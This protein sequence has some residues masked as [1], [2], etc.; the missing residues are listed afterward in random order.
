MKKILS[1]VILV[2]V[3]LLSGC[4]APQKQLTREEWLST[5][6]RTYKT[7]TKDQVIE[8]AEKVFRLA[9]GDDFNIVHAED[10]L[11]ATRPWSVYLVLAAA[12][13]IDY[14]KVVVAPGEGFVKASVQVNTSMQTV[15]P[16]PTVGGDISV[17]TSPMSGSPVMGTAIY[18][19]FWARMDYLLGVSESW[20]TCKVADQRVKDTLTWGTN[21]ALCNIFNIK[22][23]SPSSP[24]ATLS[25]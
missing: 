8:A 18:D 12:T 11:M 9:D 3:A 20:M 4:A 2:F 17:S 22:D 24:I 21:E 23:N 5:T 13:G 25:R 7:N 19:V 1:P 6:T 10:G 16:M 15:S 14:W